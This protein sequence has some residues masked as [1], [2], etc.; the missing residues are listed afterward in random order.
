MIIISQG[1]VCVLKVKASVVNGVFDSSGSDWNN[2]V[3]RLV[4]GDPHRS[5]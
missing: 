1:S 3:I 4:L 5:C 2:L